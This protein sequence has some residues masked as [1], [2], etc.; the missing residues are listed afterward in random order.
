MR[1][2]EKEAPMSFRL[3]FDETG[4]TSVGIIRDGADAAETRRRHDFLQRI[5]VPLAYLDS[6][7]KRIEAEYR[8]SDPQYERVR[9]EHESEIEFYWLDFFCAHDDLKLM[10]N[11]SV[12]QAAL[13]RE[14]LP[15][16]PENIELVYR[17]EE[18]KNSLARRPF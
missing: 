2:R 15:T 16:T 5:A 12:L 6:E 14:Q 17:L 11:R 18:V 13:D 8:S 3:I 1:K 7:I 10:A 4:V 9:R